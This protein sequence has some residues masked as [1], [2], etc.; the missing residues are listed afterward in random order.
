[1]GTPVPGLD[2]V[3]YLTSTTAME[4]NEVPGS[5]IVFG[6]GYVALEQA[7]LLPASDPK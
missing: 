1:M 2:E 7:Q 3:N 5:L 4:L 6:G